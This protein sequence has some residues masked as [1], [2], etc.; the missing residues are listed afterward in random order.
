M[1]NTFGVES[2]SAFSPHPNP[3]PWGEGNPLSRSWVVHVQCLNPALGYL[4]IGS[5]IWFSQMH[6]I[7]K[8]HCSRWRLRSRVRES[9]I[10]Q[11]SE[12][13]VDYVDATSRRLFSGAAAR[14]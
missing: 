5:G 4:V 7:R 3:L 13:P 12:P 2:L 8:Y 9:M 14:A 11:H 10:G 6:P 1:A